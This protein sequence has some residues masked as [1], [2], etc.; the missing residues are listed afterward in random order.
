MHHLQCFYFETDLE[1]HFKDCIVIHGAQAVELPKEGDKVC[2][3][4][5]QRQLPVPFAIYADFEATTKKIDSGQ[6]SNKKSYT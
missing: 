3:K 5:H 4:N 6:P 1:N 2:F